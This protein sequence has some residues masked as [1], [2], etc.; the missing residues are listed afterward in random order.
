MSLSNLDP[1]VTANKKVLRREVITMA[2]MLAKNLRLDNM[3]PAGTDFSDK[4]T[5]ELQT[6]VSSICPSVC[7]SGPS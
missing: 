2:D 4:D 5:K 7:F 6:Q 3:P 1:E